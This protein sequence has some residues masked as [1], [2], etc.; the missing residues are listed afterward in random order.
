[1]RFIDQVKTAMKK[2][3]CGQCGGKGYVVDRQVDEF[4]QKYGLATYQAAT[5][6]MEN[7]AAYGSLGSI[8]VSAWELVG[9]PPQG[10]V[11][12][13]QEAAHVHVLVACKAC[14]RHQNHPDALGA[15]TTAIEKLTANRH[16][17][18]Q[19]WLKT[20]EKEPAGE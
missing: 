2:R 12:F 9:V 16:A 10:C 11:E 3:T 14:D 15:A 5:A 8:P 18:F 17:A 6:L 4:I 1:M 13:I 7:E 19:D 20:G